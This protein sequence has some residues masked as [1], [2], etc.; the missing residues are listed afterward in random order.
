M[1]PNAVA[2]HIETLEEKNRRLLRDIIPPV[3]MEDGEGEPPPTIDIIG[4]EDIGE[5][6]NKSFDTTASDESLAS[7]LDI[8]SIPSL[9][10]HSSA[11]SNVTRFFSLKASRTNYDPS[12]LLQIEH[13]LHSESEPLN[14]NTRQPDG[15]IP[16]LQILVD[17][18]LSHP[19]RAHCRLIN[20]SVLSLFFHDLN[21]RGHLTVLRRYML[22]GDG[23]FVSGLTE[24]LFT[25][26]IETGDEMDG[27]GKRV[28][29]GLHIRLHSR[30]TWPPRGA[31]LA[32]ALKA[33]LLESIAANREVRRGRKEMVKRRGEV[34]GLED[35][36]AFGVMSDEDDE[37]NG[38]WRDPH[39]RLNM[40]R[41]LYYDILRK[42]FFRA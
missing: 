22:M 9:S 26:E 33:V 2:V 31:E 10:S 36:M 3:V 4:L 24:S 8:F 29:I 6:A 35:L 18:S 12:D 38:A 25:D 27:A 16:P 28:G 1:L 20:A 30:Q 19:L 17:Q 5:A 32:M 39:G 15:Y 40:S 37:G 41:D 34:E 42:I 7:D 21:L 14:H 13:L 11:A 23:I